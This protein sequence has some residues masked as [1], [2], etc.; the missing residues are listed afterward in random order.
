MGS[1]SR[2][3][4]F[5]V[6]LARSGSTLVE[7]ILS[8]HSRIEG[9]G[10][11]PC[12]PSVVESISL[13][14]SDEEN[15]Q[16]EAAPLAF[17]ASALRSWGERY[18]E[19]SKSF[20]RLDRPLFTD[21][22]PMNFHLL[23]LLSVMLP[24]ARIIDVRRHPVACCFSNFKQQF[25]AG[26]AQSYG[27]SDIGRYYHDYVDVMAH[28]DAVLPGRIYRVFYEDLVREPERQIR[29]LVAYCGVPFE[30]ACL[31]AHE[32]D[33]AVLT[34]SSEQVRQP[35]YDDANDSW[36]HYEQWLAPLKAALGPVLTAYPGVPDGFGQ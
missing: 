26:I 35:I 13:S 5:I 9:A 3:P 6:G 21:K 28:Y 2:E 34:V 19:F 18:V 30:E 32:S 12:L 33:R 29:A 17:E 24:K 14:D 31:G 16:D 8:R 25:P 27:L 4:I 20:R 7:Q 23:G 1:E 10:E 22:L 15:A 36:R 11:L